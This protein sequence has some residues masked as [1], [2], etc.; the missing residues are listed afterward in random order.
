MRTRMST[1]GG[2]LDTI[3]DIGQAPSGRR[4]VSQYFHCPSNLEQET[5]PSVFLGIFTNAGSFFDT[6]S[7]LR[8]RTLQSIKLFFWLE[9]LKSKSMY[10]LPPGYNLRKRDHGTSA[11]C[12]FPGTFA[13]Q[14][15]G[16]MVSRGNAEFPPSPWLPR[17]LLA[18]N[19]PPML[20]ARGFSVKG[21][22]RGI[23]TNDIYKSSFPN[24]FS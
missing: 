15:R 1:R 16:H 12:N 9:M 17:R 4:K 14:V 2:C 3:A 13:A 5:C 11:N 10:A 18:D 22:S 24:A 7:F 19:D 21:L 8:C 23:S 6:L 20:K